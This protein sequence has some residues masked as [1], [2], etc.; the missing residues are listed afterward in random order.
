MFVIKYKSVNPFQII[1]KLISKIPPLKTNSVSQIK[2]DYIYIRYK[3][4]HF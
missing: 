2:Q 3:T 1:C 4:Q